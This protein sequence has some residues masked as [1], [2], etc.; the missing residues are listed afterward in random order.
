MD[1]DLDINWDQ[2]GRAAD[3]MIENY[4]E[5]ALAE[6]QKRASNMRSA[7]RYSAAMAW[8][9]ICELIKERRLNG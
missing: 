4:G 7:G 1:I 2:M 6:G 3:G 9:R 5:N 8:V